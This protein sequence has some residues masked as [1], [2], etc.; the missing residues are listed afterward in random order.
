M[1]TLG[2][3]QVIQPLT[4]KVSRRS[5]LKALG[6]R[7]KMELTL[8]VE[9]I[10]KEVLAEGEDF[11]HPRGIFSL[12]PVE[13]VNDSEIILPGG[14][15]LQTPRIARTLFQAEIL[16][17]LLI[18][19]GPELERESDRLSE[20]GHLAKALILDT[21]GSESAEAAVGDLNLRIDRLAQEEKRRTSFRFSPGYC[22]WDIQDQK[23]IFSL[24]PGGKIGVKLSPSLMMIPK[25][26]VS[27]VVG[28]GPR[29]SQKNARHYPPPCLDC[30]QRFQ[31]LNRR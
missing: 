7:E 23:K 4:V 14:V 24:I 2:K 17:V 5:L 9:E 10:I 18:T 27:A 29:G 6:Y 26:S 25:K 20:A 21:Y 31:C 19:I 3:E 1:K 22:D 13:K 16:A 8:N 11:L 28:I 15:K 30:P 12:F